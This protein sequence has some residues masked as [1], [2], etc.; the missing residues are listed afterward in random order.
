ML[1]N[2]NIEKRPKRYYQHREDDEQKDWAEIKKRYSKANDDV[3]SYI[4]F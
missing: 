2:N 3:E 1:E 4:I